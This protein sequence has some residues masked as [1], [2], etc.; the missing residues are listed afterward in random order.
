MSIT[1]AMYRKTEIGGHHTYLFP[2]FTRLRPTFLS[3]NSR[4]EKIL[5]LIF[6]SCQIGVV[7]PDFMREHLRAMP[8]IVAPL[9]NSRN[10]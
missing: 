1:A 3:R 9:L 5:L 8:S 7:S 10:N 4:H 6:S 2:F